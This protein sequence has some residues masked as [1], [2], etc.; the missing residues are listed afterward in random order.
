MLILQN[1]K[2]Y[3]KASKREQ[4]FWANDYFWTQTNW[5]KQIKEI[6]EYEN[7]NKTWDK[8]LNYLDFIK[9]L[10]S[11][12]NWLSIWGW[13]WEEELSIV[14]KWIVENLTFVDFSEWS[15]EILRNNAKRLNIE[16]NVFTINGDL[17][18]IQLEEKKYDFI[19]C[20]MVLHHIINL[21]ECL[22]EL[23]K[24]LTDNW[25]IVI[26]EHIVPNRFQRSDERMN[27]LNKF[28]IYL[29][30]TFNIDT[31]DYFVT[32]KRTMINNCPFEAI[33]SEE[34]YNI[35]KYY[36]YNTK[37]FESLYWYLYT[38]HSFIM[39]EYNSVFY[40]EMFKIQ[41]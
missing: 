8:N 32:S 37:I 21:E 3:I 16:N 18:F 27:F 1:N 24:S 29:K 40:K 22:F 31:N 10:W 2:Y 30:N 12:K 36:F 14:S 38:D 41:S 13:F 11:F 7:F 25:I 26:E 20:R 15:N 33:R 39:K 6:E 5:E 34:L 28:R 17:N 9:T 35:I 19:I 23:N 4:S